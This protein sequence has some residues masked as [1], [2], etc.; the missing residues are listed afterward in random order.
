MEPNREAERSVAERSVAKTRGSVQPHMS[1]VS[2]PVLYFPLHS[3][4]NLIQSILTTLTRYRQ[5]RYG[6][7]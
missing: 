2:P 7:I 6:P 4:L 1:I 3:T 5:Q